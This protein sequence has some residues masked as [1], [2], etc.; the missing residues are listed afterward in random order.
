MH[1]DSLTNDIIIIKLCDIRPHNFYIL[2]K[3]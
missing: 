1:E 3:V 2:A